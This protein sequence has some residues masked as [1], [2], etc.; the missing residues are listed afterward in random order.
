MKPAAP[1]SRS[2]QRVRL[3]WDSSEWS[4]LVPLL[5][6][7]LAQQLL[8]REDAARLGLQ[9]RDQFIFV[10]GQPQ[11]DTPD[12]DPATGRVDQQRADLDR[13][14]IIGPGASKMLP[15]M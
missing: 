9:Q 3:A 10:C 8:L 13:G 4:L 7:Q 1:A 5:P 6:P 12:L 14:E 11:L 15:S 2:L